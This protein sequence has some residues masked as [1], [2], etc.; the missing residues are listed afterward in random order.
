MSPTL[1]PVEGPP[2]PAPVAHGADAAPRAA[3]SASRP[4]ID[5]EALLRQAE[6][7]R[8][9][10]GGRTAEFSYD[11]RL[12]RIIVR[13]LSGDRPGGEVVRQIPPQEYVNFVSR[14]REMLGVLLNETF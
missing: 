12:D 1:F 8:V 7:S 13:V 4:A 9:A 5:R 3:E 14:F 10:L 2:A 6:P 11:P